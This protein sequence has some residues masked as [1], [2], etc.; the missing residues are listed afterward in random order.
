MKLT[1]KLF[2]I[3]NN[4]VRKIRKPTQVKEEEA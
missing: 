4:I 3:A 2:M 1:L